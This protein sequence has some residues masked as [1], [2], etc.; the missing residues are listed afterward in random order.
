[1]EV[2]ICIDRI[3][4]SLPQSLVIIELT[5]VARLNLPISLT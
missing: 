2:T 1:M 4:L 5:Y 3:L